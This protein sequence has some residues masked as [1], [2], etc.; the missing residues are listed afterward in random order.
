M[1]RNLTRSESRLRGEI[2]IQPILALDEQIRE[3]EAALIKLK[4]AR[5]SLLNVS[6]LPPEVLGNI[7]RW[8][9]TLEGDFG[10]LEE[11][12]HN[13]LFVCHHWFEVALCTPELWS[14][15]GSTPQDWARWCRRSATAPLDLVLD[16]NYDEDP[17]D[18]A[19][20]N[21]LQDRAT[22]DTIRR[23]HL[24]A[25]N[26]KLLNSVIS[27]LTAN[28]EEPRSN[29][30]ESFILRNESDEP[31]DISDFF[32]H[33]RFPKLLHLEL[34][35]CTVSPWD[36][37]TS[38]TTVLTTLDIE[39]YY[40]SPTITSQLLSA[41]VSCP[42]LR[43]VSLSW[44]GGR[45]DGGGNPSLRASLDHL[46]E[47]KLSGVPQG[48][49]GLLH[50]SNHPRRMDIAL[51]RCI[52]KD[53]PQTIGPYLRDYLRRRGS[54]QIGLGLSL[55]AGF[56]D[57]IKLQ[58]SDVG[59]IDFCDPAPARM[60]TFVEITIDFQRMLPGDRLENLAFNLIAHVPR[61]EIAYLRMHDNVVLENLSTKLPNL[62]GLHLK[63]TAL[64]ATFLGP[65]LNRDGGLLPSLQSLFLDHV[66]VDD[67]DWTPLMTFL[68]HRASSGN[69][70]HSL[71]IAGSCDT[72]PEMSRVLEEAVQE[73]RWN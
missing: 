6:T 68:A 21:V 5:N 72:T 56:L 64:L 3:H 22:R 33:Y 27:P 42:T 17:L 23:V 65:T 53:I 12:S 14:F 1:D 54:S 52:A 32:S 16:A 46:E 39:S 26:S 11:G 66:N 48:V 31:V 60:N 67:G 25:E 73:F 34:C 41:L 29:S 4:R 59:G 43:K 28:S 61:E 24:K 36:L 13:F 70:L 37:I 9:V 18:A 8:N 30:V 62:R 2:N 55:T 45:S 44:F 47:L 63:G 49:F 57:R 38:R 50:R 40:L 15:W 35:G 58:I 20:C 19:L 71:V 51:Y 10:E 7:F 69:R